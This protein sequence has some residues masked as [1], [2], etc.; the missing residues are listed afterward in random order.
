MSHIHKFNLMRKIWTRTVK[1]RKKL[2]TGTVPVNNFLLTRTAPVNSFL[3]TWMVPVNNFWMTKK[4]WSLIP[5]WPDIYCTACQHPE[6]WPAST[7]GHLSQLSQRK[8]IGFRSIRNYWAKHYYP[9]DCMRIVQ[10]VQTSVSLSYLDSF[11]TPPFI[12]SPVCRL[13]DCS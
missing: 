5:Y 4:L 10:N 9:R 11:Y 7:Y 12:L 8:K 6:A 1:I 2:L 13:Q 3:F